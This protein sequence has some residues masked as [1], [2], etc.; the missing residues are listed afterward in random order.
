MNSAAPARAKRRC[1]AA[2]TKRTVNSRGFQPTV[3]EAHQTGP[4]SCKK[5]AR[6]SVLRNGSAAVLH[7]LKPMAIQSSPLRGAERKSGTL[8]LPQTSAHGVQQRCGTCSVFQ[9]G[10]FPKSYLTVR[11]LVVHAS[12]GHDRS[13][14]IL[15]A[16]W[17]RSCSTT[18]SGSRPVVSTAIA[19]GAFTMGDSFLDS[20]R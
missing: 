2:W 13:S 9:E 11:T 18:F 4:A 8:P 14:G 19:S 15:S 12:R 16:T 3:V 17:D 1:F 6:E 20:S 7:G 10:V 5:V